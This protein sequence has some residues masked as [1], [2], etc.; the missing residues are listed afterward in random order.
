VNERGGGRFAEPGQDAATAYFPNTPVVS[1]AAFTPAQRSTRTLSGF[2]AG[3]ES[4]YDGAGDFL[5]VQKIATAA[6]PAGLVL[7]TDAGRN[8]VSATF[9]LSTDV[10][11]EQASID[12]GVTPGEGAFIDDRTFM[13]LSPEG[14]GDLA[15]VASSALQH[16]GFLPAGVGF[17]DCEYLSWGFLYGRRVAAGGDNR[18][19]ELASWV[20]G[21]PSDV[22]QIVGVTPQTATYSGH[23]IAGVQNGGAIYQA[24]GSM[25]LQVTFGAGAFSLDRVDITNFDGVNLSGVNGAGAQFATNAYDSSAFTITGQHPTAGTIAAQ[26]NGA[27]FG[28]GTP[29]LETGGQMAIS[30]A[31]YQAQGTY[32]ARRPGP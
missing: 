16:E 23:V 7:S 24:A 28:P 19:I 25:R 2:A 1:G 26:V 20:A 27:F 12:F 13:A 11:L 5:G 4:R 29:P 9:D 10:D 31:A 14:S 22:S 18:V 15:M 32:A 17:C 21:A 6:D 8:T 3:L 30:G